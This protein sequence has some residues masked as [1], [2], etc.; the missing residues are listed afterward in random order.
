LTS[1]ETASICSDS[2]AYFNA[3]ISVADQCKLLAVGLTTLATG[4]TDASIQST[5][6]TFYTACTTG[7]PSQTCDTGQFATCAPTAT[8]TEFSTCFADNTAATKVVIDGLP[9]C[10]A[11]TAASLSTL[12]LTIPPPASCT[13]LLAECP[14]INTGS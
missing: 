12:N 2:E 11:L 13:T 5:C 8:V 9:A 14:D 6:T 1:A 3:H 4:G 7:G 10:S